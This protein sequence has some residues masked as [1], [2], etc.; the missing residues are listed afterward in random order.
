[1]AN[2]DD[3]AFNAM[4]LG[5]PDKYITGGA[6]EYS[7]Y[8]MDMTPKQQEAY[9]KKNASIFKKLYDTDPLVNRE[10]LSY[11]SYLENLD[12]RMVRMRADDH[13]KEIQGSTEKADPYLIAARDIDRLSRQHYGDIDRLKDMALG[14]GHP[15]Y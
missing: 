1:M 10:K 15:L 6:M 5:D 2:I 12:S 4:K 13:R 3:Q 11:K 9:L 14:K 7:E 8:E